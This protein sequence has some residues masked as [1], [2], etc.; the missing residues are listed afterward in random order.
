MAKQEHIELLNN[1][2]GSTAKARQLG[3]S[4][5]EH[6]MGMAKIGREE[7]AVEWGYG[8]FI[9]ALESGELDEAIAG[10]LGYC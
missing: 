6:A 5:R 2:H 10:L 7:G 3:L 9:A 1:F 4:P 8:D